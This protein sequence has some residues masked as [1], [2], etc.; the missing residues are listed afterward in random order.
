MSPDRG[1]DVP[2]FELV[3]ADISTSFEEV[4]R[5]AEK[6]YG[7]ST[8]RFVNRQTAVQPDGAVVTEEARVKKAE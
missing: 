3:T 6:Q 7:R 1:L 5:E 8:G 4:Q 2:Q